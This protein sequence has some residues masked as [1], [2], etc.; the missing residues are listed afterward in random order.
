MNET[1]KKYLQKIQRLGKVERA[2]LRSVLLDEETHAEFLDLVTVLIEESDASDEA[3]LEDLF[4]F[5]AQIA[6]LWP[7]DEIR[8]EFSQ[9]DQSVLAFRSGFSGDEFTTVFSVEAL[10][11]LERQ[12]TDTAMPSPRQETGRSASKARSKRRGKTHSI[13]LQKHSIAA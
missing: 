6:D 5:G 11:D 8:F 3:A 12:A 1:F 13:E 9:I 7:E 2:K 4:I 10:A